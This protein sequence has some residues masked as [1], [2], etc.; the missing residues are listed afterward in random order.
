MRQACEGYVCQ[1]RPCPEFVE[2]AFKDGPIVRFCLRICCRAKGPP[3]AA[4]WRLGTTSSGVI[5]QTSNLR[6]SSVRDHGEPEPGRLR[7]I[8]L[9][10]EVFQWRL[11][12]HAADIDI[13]S[14]SRHAPS[15]LRLGPG[16]VPQGP[17]VHDRRDFARRRDRGQPLVIDPE[18]HC[19]SAEAGLNAA[20]MISSTRTPRQV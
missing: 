20:P 17:Q 5:A 16:G 8:I 12:P 10:R 2:H 3:C 11:S 15:V 1:P 13:W 7:H 14:G 18:D 9:G 19:P 6:H 4:R